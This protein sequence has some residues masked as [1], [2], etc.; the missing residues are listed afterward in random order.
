MPR[1]INWLEHQWS[2]H[3]WKERVRSATQFAMPR[4][5]ETHAV[6]PPSVDALEPR[7]LFSGSLDG[8]VQID[9]D[10]NDLLGAA[11]MPAEAVVVFLDAD[12]DGQLDAGETQASTD[13]SG[14]YSLGVLADGAH[15]VQTVIPAGYLVQGGGDGSFDVVISGQ[16]VTQDL[17]LE[18][19]DPYPFGVFNDTVDFGSGTLAGNTQYDTPSG[20]YT[21]EGGGAEVW[22]KRDYFHFARDTHNGDGVAE[23]RIVSL[24]NTDPDAKA[25]IMFR[26]DAA[27]SRSANVFLLVKPD[28]EVA[29]QRRGGLNWSTETVASADLTPGNR[30]LRLE[31]SGELFTAFYKDDSGD[32]Q[33]LAATNVPIAQLGA[34]AQVGLGVTSGDNTQLATA[35]F[36]QV[37]MPWSPSQGGDPGATA[38]DQFTQSTD[39]GSPTA[40]GQYTH[41][42]ADDYYVVNGGGAGIGNSVDEFQF[43]Y[44]THE[45]NGSAYARVAGLENTDSSARAGIMFRESADADAAYVLLTTRPDGDVMLQWRS[46]P[47]GTVESSSLWNLNGHP[48][49]INLT[50]I[51]STFYAHY[52]NNQ[53]EWQS[54]GYKTINGFA[55]TALVG[56]AVTSADTAQTATAVFD[57]VHMP[58]SPTEYGSAITGLYGHFGQH[59]NVGGSNTLPGETHYDAATNTYNV[60]GGGWIGDKRDYF[61]YA[62][63]TIQEGDGVADA[64]IVSLENTHA[65]AKAG[66][67]FRDSEDL[68][69]A[70]VFFWVQPDGTVTLTRRLDLNWS[71]E[72]VATQALTPGDR[73]LRLERAADLYTA[74]YKDD[75]GDWQLLATTTVPVAQLR[76]D[77]WIGLGVTSQDNTQLAT[78]VF[79]QVTMP[80][81]FSQSS[82]P[83]TYETSNKLDDPNNPGQLVVLTGPDSG[84]RSGDLN[85]DRHVD[86]RDIDAMFA[87]A[88]GATIDGNAM[89]TPNPG[90]VFNERYDLFPDGVI[91]KLD[92]DHLIYGLL[93]TE[94]GDANLDGLVDSADSDLLLNG[95]ASNGSGWAQGDF[96]GDG[97]ASIA[98]LSYWQ[99]H[100][101]FVAVA[102][103]VID[104]S[105]ETE[106]QI[107]YG[108]MGNDTL[109][110]GTGEDFIWGGAGVDVIDGGPDG[111]DLLNGGGQWD[112]QI[113]H[114]SAD[115]FTGFVKVSELAVATREPNQNAP[116]VVYSEPLLNGVKYRFK[117]SGTAS[118]WT[119]SQG[120]YADAE[121][122]LTSDGVYRNKKDGGTRVDWGLAVNDQ[123]PVNASPSDPASGDEYQKPNRWTSIEGEPSAYYMT[124]IGRGEPVS[125]F[126]LD[127]GYNDN[128]GSLQVEIFAK[129]T[130]EVTGTVWHDNNP[131]NGVR[132]VSAAPTP[133]DVVLLIDASLSTND[134]YDGTVRD[135]NAQ[136]GPGYEGT[137]FDAHLD[138][139][140][141]INDALAD[142]YQS[143]VY[144]S[145]PNVAVVTFGPDEIVLVTSGP[146]GN[147]DVVT[148]GFEEAGQSVTD[149]IRSIKQPVPDGVPAAPSPSPPNGAQVL[150]IADSLEMALRHVRQRWAPNRDLA[151]AIISDGHASHYGGFQEQAQALVG[152]AD[153]DQQDLRV[154]GSDTSLDGLGLVDPNASEFLSLES[155]AARF[156]DEIQRNRS[157][158]VEPGL[159]GVR[160][161]ADLNNNG[162]FDA[163][164]PADRTNSDG[165]YILDLAGRQDGPTYIIRVERPDDQ[166]QPGGDGL[167][168]WGITAPLKP[169]LYTVDI[170]ASLRTEGAD[171]GLLDASTDSDA[172]GIPDYVEFVNPEFF[173]PNHPDNLNPGEA[174]NGDFDHDND[175][176]ST[177]LE[178]QIGTDP[179]FYDTDNDLLPDGWE[180]TYW[181][182]VAGEGPFNPLIPDDPLADADGDGLTNLDEGIWGSDPTNPDTDGD[183]TSDKDESDQGSDPN[184]PS[185]YGQ[186]LPDDSTASF[187]IQ[188]GDWS[189]SNSERFSLD[190]GDVSV[191]AP[192]FGEISP[193]KTFNGFEAGTTHNASL[194][195][196]ATDHEDGPDRDWTAIIDQV[197]NPQG[198]TIPSFIVDPDN[199][200]SAGN[201]SSPG[202]PNPVAGKSAKLVIP[203]LDLDIEGIDDKQELDPAQAKLLT[204]DTDDQDADGIPDWADIALPNHRDFV[205]VTLE[206][207]DNVKEAWESGQFD[208][209]GTTITFAYAGPGQN[210]IDD[211]FNLPTGDPVADAAALAAMTLTPGLRLWKDDANEATDFLAPG[212]AYTAD[213]L[214]LPPG[215]PITLKLDAHPG[216]LPSALQITATAAI[217]GDIWN[218]SLDDTSHAK[219]LGTVFSMVASDGTVT[220]A[221]EI[222]ISAPSPTF[223][224][225]NLKLENL[226]LSPDNERLVADLQIGATLDDA[227]SDMIEGS[228]GQIDTVDV[229]H[230]GEVIHT[231][232]L[233][234]GDISKNAQPSSLLKPFDFSATFTETLNGIEVE[235]GMNLFRLVAE[236][237]YGRSGFVE[238]GV[239][240]LATAPADETFGYEVIVTDD[241]YVEGDTG[242]QIQLRTQGADGNWGNW[243]AL[244]QIDADTFSLAGP[245]LGATIDFQLDEPLVTS[246][247][248][249][250]RW[251]T[252]T[253]N[254]SGSTT[255]VIKLTHAGQDPVTGATLWEG[256]WTREE[257][258]LP[259]LARHT[260]SIG[261]ETPLVASDGGEFHPVLLGPDAKLADGQTFESAEINGQT[262]DIVDYQGGLYFAHPGDTLPAA[263]LMAP[264][265]DG[266]VGEAPDTLAEFGDYIAGVGV[267]LLETVPD[268]IMGLW[269][270][271]TFLGGA[272]WHG[273]ANYNTPTVIYRIATQG[274]L[275][276]VE[277]QKRFDTALGV[278]QT[279][280]NVIQK[281]DADSETAVAAWLTGDDTTL[282][283][284]GEE[285]VTAFSFAA[286][287]LSEVWDEI[288]LQEPYEVG[289]IVG[290]IAGE[291]VLAVT[292]AG[293]GT[294]LKGATMVGVLN[295][296]KD[297]KYI[298]R[299]SQ[300]MSRLD[301]L[302]DYYNSIDELVDGVEGGITEGR[303]I[304]DKIASLVMEH[305]RK[306]PNTP[307]W[308]S[309]EYFLTETS[310]P[311][312]KALLE[313]HLG[314]ASQMVMNRA[315][316][317]AADIL[318]AD[319]SKTWADV[320]HLVPTWQQIKN[321]M[322]GRLQ[323]ASLETHHTATKEWMQVLIDGITDAELNQMPGLV[324]TNAWHRQYNAVGMPRDFVFHNILKEKMRN[325]DRSD[326]DD[327][328]GRL[329]LTYRDF[330][331]LD[332]SAPDPDAWIVTESWIRQARAGA[333]E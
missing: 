17:T 32:W 194:R 103:V 113:K 313:S 44:E 118:V 145:A 232:H 101:G 51:D 249:T 324:L 229:I 327:I 236:N 221:E 33:L 26:N 19:T 251:I 29:L 34:D 60:Q 197:P 65:D 152:R 7:L 283:A 164:E 201:N 41:D 120:S 47:G 309:W 307:I 199:I 121:I 183:G 188:V 243:R 86:A 224:N 219:T 205:E 216:F 20:T 230:N 74:S 1:W 303:V 239:E 102:P 72:T 231:I 319:T 280:A 314:Y 68:R 326:A 93:Q 11:P 312:R 300:L 160:V 185:D 151:V 207:S 126:Y 212:V 186:P 287:L 107:I 69:A 265:Y 262:Y 27:D 258:D 91:N 48:R 141:R 247:S 157:V 278:A 179:T 329:R 97:I 269:D 9:T 42:A 301:G 290:R 66:I 94:Y 96:N 304:A 54:I 3:V 242:L 211:L 295:K 56:L 4:L 22:N 52:L 266:P 109:T 57:R 136:A 310:D 267:G 215:S 5:G 82:G 191:V 187:N 320:Q 31:R 154:F 321:R 315:Y 125:F 30:E 18:P 184:D 67:M 112:D 58:W 28:G 122:V 222:P 76:T 225:V 10:P 163:G 220:E 142:L 178:G 2:L 71:M 90:Y 333:I 322:G 305:Q 293:I 208:A 148:S 123:P 195:W 196:L 279:I 308:E 139:A 210:E 274:T 318:R 128:T 268:T 49:E 244:E 302:Y 25:G 286:E 175:G 108:R 202:D 162:V 12:Q 263:F 114:G 21:L 134:P 257:H 289:R 100:S 255:E 59:L 144:A 192:S 106:P 264:D 146:D 203:Q 332:E 87:E 248:T 177:S 288:S 23:A 130:S 79:D 105:T 299:F 260:L 64:R 129:P 45:G 218:G 277:D 276:T 282:V 95:I 149:A 110:G 150:D 137:K 174:D 325:V 89:M 171:F 227:V 127:D 294:A 169:T 55:D 159:D 275:L 316:K 78:A 36:D 284:L 133:P 204:A 306:N 241:P 62:Y 124:Y 77:A 117:A 259:D 228:E 254:A 217:N 176:L 297:V 40:T 50:R 250:E 180:Y 292:T 311:R 53:G 156:V 81:S 43:V 173:D 206:L 161:Y 209:E 234:S 237:A 330:Y 181:N 135:Y 61:Q 182:K 273:I 147:Y 296:L 285:Y 8:N 271:I 85:G 170:S 323:A 13:A 298:Q 253:D 233:N 131:T 223:S 331:G 153:F 92:V 70:N 73:E 88:Q 167:P 193:P 158:F 115:P 99:D 235:P 75:N 84:W 14:A 270:G 6:S 198:V 238:R 246:D 189:G 165:E 226:Q 166:P 214:G 261:E 38:D 39:I 15:R 155:A 256:D 200:I 37:T 46:T 16:D 138:V 143:G 317:D 35:V 24:E 245:T 213:D 111:A 140:E 272:A 98:D 168:D 190:V 291:V 80:W 116:Q 240:A 83:I 63:A 252:L 132:D 172:D 328:I 281:L 119:H 104:A